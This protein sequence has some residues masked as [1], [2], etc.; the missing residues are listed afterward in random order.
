MRMTLHVKVSAMVTMEDV[1][2]Q[3]E[4]CE[5]MR[6]CN[7][8]AVAKLATALVAA[9][10]SPVVE[11]ACKQCAY[12]CAPSHASAVVD[13]FVG[14]SDPS[15]STRTQE[16]RRERTRTKLRGLADVVATIVSGARAGHGRTFSAPKNAA[17][18]RESVSAI[19]K[20]R[21]GADAVPNIAKLPARPGLAWAGVVALARS[22]ARSRSVQKPLVA[23]ARLWTLFGVDTHTQRP[24]RHEDHGAA[25]IDSLDTDTKL[26]VLWSFSRE[27]GSDPLVEVASTAPLDKVVEC[28][29][30]Q[31]V[32]T[33]SEVACVLA[34]P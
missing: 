34:T 2:D 6:A 33:G 11:R 3:S 22:A 30:L 28:T 17:A 24:D 13:F 25:A 18:L 19:M 8:P 5:S 21:S 14:T 9:G 12:L 29:A 26:S 16:G 20:S 10:R 31:P 4:L 1:S 27:R 23:N 32:R 15:S 7:G